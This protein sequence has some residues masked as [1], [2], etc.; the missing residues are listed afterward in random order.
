[1]RAIHLPSIATQSASA[2]RNGIFPPQ[3]TSPAPLVRA[4][5]IPPLTSLHTC[6]P[7][8]VLL[9]P[10]SPHATSSK[11]APHPAASGKPNYAAKETEPFLLLFIRRCSIIE[12]S[13]YIACNSRVSLFS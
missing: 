13:K 6:S 8:R 9:L 11:A 7:A 1:A 2:N 4:P 12:Q 10:Q 3:A 5:Q